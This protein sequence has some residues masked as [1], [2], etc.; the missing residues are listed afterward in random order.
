MVLRT[1]LH[2]L[3]TVE[4]NLLKVNKWMWGRTDIM[5]TLLHA[6]GFDCDG[7]LLSL[8]EENPERCVANLDGV[9]SSAHPQ[10]MSRFPLKGANSLFLPL[11]APFF[12]THAHMANSLIHPFPLLLGWQRG[13]EQNTMASTDV[14]DQILELLKK[15][16]G[17][18][19][20]L[21]VY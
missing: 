6:E 5:D 8:D 13:K 9:K 19:T 4:T 17:A 7:F 21:H 1:C 10:G 2:G 18:M 11:H 16:P 14:T 20:A 3:D 12:S 15:S